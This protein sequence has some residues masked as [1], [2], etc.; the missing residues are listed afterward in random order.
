VFIRRIMEA[1]MDIWVNLSAFYSLYAVVNRNEKHRWERTVKTKGHP[2][3]FPV[4][5]LH[6]ALPPARRPTALRYFPARVGTA[7][8]CAAVPLSATFA[9]RRPT[10]RSAAPARQ[11]QQPPLRNEPLS[12]PRRRPS[13]PPRSPA[14][15]SAPLRPGAGRGLVPAIAAVLSASE[16]W[17]RRITSRAARRSGATKRTEGR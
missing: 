13:A 8:P 4:K 10:P 15:R 14:R 11:Q 6:G 2:T 9:R 17:R 5:L 16:L 1:V 7:F 12:A 3:L